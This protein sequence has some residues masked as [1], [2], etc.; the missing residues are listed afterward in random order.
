MMVLPLLQRR[1]LS[2]PVAPDLISL[3]RWAPVLSCVL[4]PRTSPTCRGELRCCHVSHGLGPRFLAELSSSAAMCSSGSDLASL[5]R[6]APTLPRVSWL[7]ALPPREESSGAATYS[8]TPSGLW[9]TGIKKGLAAPGTQVGSH[10]SKTCSRITETPARR[11]D[12]TLQFGSIV[13]RRP[14]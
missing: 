1:P 8:I 13:Q 5:S 7:Q 9:T 14:N 12:K 2:V 6:W 4:Q 11:V 3:T 10:A